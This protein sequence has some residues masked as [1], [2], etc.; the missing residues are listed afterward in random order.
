MQTQEEKEICKRCNNYD[1]LC[2]CCSDCGTY[3]KSSCKCSKE[4]TKA[5][6]QKTFYELLDEL[7][8][9]LYWESENYQQ[10]S[11]YWLLM[12]L[13]DIIV[14]SGRIWKEEFKDMILTAP[15]FFAEITKDIKK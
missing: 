5:E 14:K 3:R 11:H 2:F 1:E 7:E 4:P 8:N 12:L 9:F 6:K 15:Y 13:R 10:Q